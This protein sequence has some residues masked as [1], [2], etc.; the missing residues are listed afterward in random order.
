[1]CPVRTLSFP[2]E[3]NDSEVGELDSGVG[4]PVHSV[5]SDRLH[6]PK[7]PG[8]DVEPRGNTN[9]GSRS[10]G[11]GHGHS[12]S[13]RGIWGLTHENIN[14]KAA[15]GGAV[16]PSGAAFLKGAERPRLMKGNEMGL[17]QIKTY[18]IADSYVKMNCITPFMLRQSA[19][20]AVSEEACPAEGWMNLCLTKSHW[21]DGKRRGFSPA[22]VEYNN[23]FIGYFQ[24]VLERGG[25]CLH[26]SAVVVD[27]ETVLFSADSGTGK[28]THAGLWE[29]YLS[30]Q[31]RVVRLNDDKPVLRVQENMVWAYGSPW[32]GKH[33]I[34]TNTKAPVKALVFLEQAPKNEIRPVSPQ[35]GFSMVFSQ[36]FSVKTDAR[37]RI[38]MLQLLDGFLR[39][40]PIYHLACNIS[41]EAVELVYD[42]IWKGDKQ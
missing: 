17:D 33:L 4:G 8:A 36:T 31:H 5:E 16:S 7:A 30:N 21:E 24:N 34:H 19:P 18:K 32:S 12:Q 27:G 1:M 11:G 37:Q 26:A 9:P 15:L 35:E 41:R 14:Q 22:M 20:Y 28:S 40:V 2:N 38:Q 39:R 25:F 29:K 13:R 42:T 6:K 10:P 23:T 3:T